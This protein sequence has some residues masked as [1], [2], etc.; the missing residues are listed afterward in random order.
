MKNKGKIFEDDF[1]KSIPDNCWCKRLNDNAASWSGGNA[2]RFSSTNECDFLL[3]DIE[4]KELFAL[5]LKST[6]GS[7]TFWREDFEKNK[8]GATYAIKKNQIIGLQKFKTYHLICGLIFNFRNKNN[9]TYFVD[10]SD[11]INYT[12]LLSKKSINIHDVRNMQNI[13]I[14]NTLLQTHY[15]YNISKFIKEVCGSCTLGKSII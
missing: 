15:R 10:I 9:E 12:N 5:E 3:R 4:T 11:F 1:K 6:I 7:L 13:Q 8:K 2:T 14:E